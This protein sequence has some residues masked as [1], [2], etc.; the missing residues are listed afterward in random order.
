MA[1]R[2]ERFA[3]LTAYDA[4]T[5]RWLERGGVHVLLVGDSAAQVVLGYERTLDMPLDIAV[6]LCAAVKRGAPRTLVM[7][8]MPFASYHQS[9]AQAVRNAARFMTEG[10]A[11]VVKLEAD[12]SFAPTVERLTRAGIP[13]CAHVGCR[14]QTVA[15]SGGYRVAGRTAADAR[16]VVADASA[17]VRA[18]AVLVLIEAAPAE[19]TRALVKAVDVPVIGIGAGTECHGQ[20]LVVQDLLGMTDDPPRFAEAV[21]DLGPRTR[22]AAAEWVRR[23]SAGNIGGQR[24]VMDEGE[25]DRLGI[26][27]PRSGESDQEPGPGGPMHH[28][29]GDRARMPREGS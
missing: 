18:G 26:R 25:A 3:C 2:G 13:V 6:A 27:E 23:V 19:V 5:A 22:D 9:N 16:R 17:L 20:V 7:A 11:D 29:S 14:P 24:Y 8:D 28:V 12:A 4:T 10:L 15:V 1:S 21:A